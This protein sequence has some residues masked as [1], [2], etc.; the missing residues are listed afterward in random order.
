[1]LIKEYIIAK[2]CKKVANC[3]GSGVWGGRE[4]NR[5]L[6]D[7]KYSKS[8]HPSTT[9]AHL[10]HFVNAILLLISVNLPLY[11][12]KY[13]NQCIYALN[14]S[15][16]GE[17]MLDKTE[18]IKESQIILVV[19]Y[20]TIV[21]KEYEDTAKIL[22][23]KNLGRLFIENIYPAYYRSSYKDISKI[24]ISID[25]TVAEFDEVPYV[26]ADK[27]ALTTVNKI[28]IIS[29]L[30]T[31][32]VSALIVTYRMNMEE[33]ADNLCHYDKKATK[34]IS[35]DFIE[36]IKEME[37][38]SSRYRIAMQIPLFFKEEDEAIILDIPGSHYGYITER[39][40]LNVHDNR[41]TYD[42]HIVCEAY[43]LFS[44][45]AHIVLR[46]AY[47]SFLTNRIYFTRTKLNKDIYTRDSSFDFVRPLAIE[48]KQGVLTC[49]VGLAKI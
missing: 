25:E 32:N 17:T 37:A 24:I 13:S 1:M 29:M 18:Y 35:A 7:A 36:S 21:T 22:S 2:D 3:G 4:T 19:P 48:I 27:S 33:I 34:K 28:N 40:M 42:K 5:M 12:V 49:K 47:K 14:Y 8:P 43:N 45:I 44:R 23:K 20:I 6:N 26:S 31:N 16:K 38:I 9:P 10:I 30:G 41:I 15:N 39:A 46:E 11:A